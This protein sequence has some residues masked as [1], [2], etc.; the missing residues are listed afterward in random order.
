MRARF[1]FA[2]AGVGGVTLVLAAMCVAWAQSPR[3]K[4][5]ASPAIQSGGTTM[6]IPAVATGTR[7]V[8]RDSPATEL[9]PQAP[10]LYAS[11]P[12]API[13]AKPAIIELRSGL[14]L[15]GHLQSA[16][17]P[18]RTVFGEASLPLGT[19]RGIR[20][21]E[22]LTS[23]EGGEPQPTGATM[24][25]S[26]GDSLTGVPQLE[27]FQI[28]TEWGVA[29]V[30]LSHLKSLVLTDEKVTWEEA[31]G[32]W[33]LTPAAKPSEVG[34]SAA[35]YSGAPADAIP[36]PVAPP[37]AVPPPGTRTTPPTESA[38]PTVTES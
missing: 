26:N 36:S 1:I 3:S 4:P 28:Q 29:I 9:S 15:E 21:S 13:P 19:I 5:A 6:A 2:A 34:E 31:E 17:I 38:V 11:L 22:E 18:C 14:T 30:K 33:R 32:R 8:F 35:D 24:I 20:M 23:V 25:L 10:N 7:T 16:H 37:V 12:P 27:V